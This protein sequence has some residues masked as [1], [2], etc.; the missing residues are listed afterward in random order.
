MANVDIA[1]TILTRGA[2][3]CNGAGGCRCSMV[4]PFSRRFKATNDRPYRRATPPEL[5]TPN[6][7]A[8]DMPCAY[9]GAQTP[10]QVL[11]VYH[12]VDFGNGCVRYDEIENYHLRSDPSESQLFPAPGTAEAR[13]NSRSGPR[14]PN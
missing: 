1:P 14:P 12:S 3:P 9:Q 10:D 7:G 11:V 2:Q 13:N 6:K 5:N 8:P 4:A